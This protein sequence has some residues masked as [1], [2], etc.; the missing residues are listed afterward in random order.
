MTARGRRSSSKEL[1][2]LYALGGALPTLRRLDEFGSGGLFRL[3]Q[4]RIF[5]GF[6]ALHLVKST[7]AMSISRDR[8]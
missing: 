8:E 1:D 3:S 7:F 2:L 5:L 4:P 6:C